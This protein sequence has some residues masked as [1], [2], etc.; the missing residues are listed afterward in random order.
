VRRLGDPAI[1]APSSPC[2]ARAAPG[3]G[4][5]STSAG[6][7][8]GHVGRALRWRSALSRSLSSGDLLHRRHYDFRLRCNDGRRFALDVLWRRS[9]FFLFRPGLFLL[10]HRRRRWNWRVHVEHTENRLGVTQ[11][12]LPGHVQER[13]EKRRVDSSD[14]CNRAAACPRADVGAIGHAPSTRTPATALRKQLFY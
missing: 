8:A 11:T 6:A 10:L 7:R 2:P 1:T 9:A 13:E 5:S 3:P 14:G 4:P 12:D